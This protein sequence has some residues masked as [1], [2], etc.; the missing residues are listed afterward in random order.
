MQYAQGISDGAP[1]AI[2]I[3]DRWHLLKNLSEV[4]ERVLQQLLPQLKQRTIQHASRSAPRDKFPRAKPDQVKQATTR[5]QRLREYTLI[6]YLHRRGYGERQIARVLGMSRG[7]VSRYIDAETFPERKAHYVPSILDRYLTYL[8]QRVQEG[9]MNATQLW[10]EIREQGYPGGSSQVSKWMQ[11]RRKG[12]QP[13]QAQSLPL[14][15]VSLPDIRTCIHLITASPV[16][17]SSEEAVLLDILRSVDS[18][19][20]LYDLV[21]AFAAMVRQR[22]AQ[23][24]D[25]WLATCNQ[26]EFP[27][28]KHFAAS[29]QQDYD[30]VYSALDLPWSNGQTEGQVN[31]LK[32]LK[33]QMY[34]RANLDLLRLRMLYSP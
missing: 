30:A 23:A 6:Q 33:R 13:I 8:E 16:R 14:T 31:R 18:L 25:A 27:G 24:L 2:Q 29:L 21:Q 32:L 12:L 10:R 5:A 19:R 22:Q 9:C 17:L 7:K 1:Q 4:V 28:L 26:T 15:P 34:G 3:A 20:M 11:N